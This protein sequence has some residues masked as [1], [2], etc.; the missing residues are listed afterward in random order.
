MRADV[1][2]NYNNDTEKYKDYN[3]SR[4]SVKSFK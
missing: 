1:E 2:E 4:K 3:A